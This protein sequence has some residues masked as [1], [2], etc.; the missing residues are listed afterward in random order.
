MHIHVTAGS[1]VTSSQT[2]HSSTMAESAC[3]RPL[4]FA[5]VFGIECLSLL[6][7]HPMKRHA[8]RQTGLADALPQ[9]DRESFTSREP[10]A[11]SKRR[12][13]LVH[14]A[15]S[16]PRHGLALEQRVERLEAHHAAARGIESALDRDCA[17]IK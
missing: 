8:A 7:A 10:R 6:H 13:L 15:A 1:P 4:R 5:A 3:I 14:V 9:V 17:P 11:G 16:E 2:G 12:D